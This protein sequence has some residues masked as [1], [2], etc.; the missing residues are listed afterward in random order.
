MRKFL[1]LGVGFAGFALFLTITAAALAGASANRSSAVSIPD[2][3][4]S[5]LSAVPGNDWVSP[6][7]NLAGNRYSSLTT[8]TPANVSGVKLAWHV[9]LN[10]PVPKG[11]DPAALFGD[12]STAVESGGTL[13]TSDSL[14]RVYAL[15]AATGKQLWYYEPNNPKTPEPPASKIP[16]P[17]GIS[18]AGAALGASRGVAINDGLV[19][20]FNEGGDA[21]ALD[22]STGKLVWSDQVAPLIQGVGLS[23]APLY[24]NGVIYGATA[25]GDQGEFPCFAFALDA[26]TGKMLW[27]FNIIPG[28]A[29]DP[30]YSTWAHPLPARGGGAMWDTPS[31]DPTTGDVYFGTGNPIPYMGLLR[32]PGQEHFTDG[33]LALNA[34][35]GKEAWFF[36][37]VHHDIWDADQSQAP[38]VYNGTVGGQ[39]VD[40]IVT[41]DK[42]GLWYVLDAATGKPVL[43]VTEMKVQQSA[44]AH[45]WAT[46]PIP[47]TT[48]LVPQTVPDPAAWKNLKAPNGKPWNIGPGGAAGS[49][50]GAD[51]TRYSVTAAFGQ[52]ASG[53]KPGSV[54]P[55]KGLLIEETTPGFTAYQAIPSSEVSKL[56]AFNFSAV[57]DM[58]IAPLTGTPAAAVTGTRIE[59]MS[60]ATGKMVWKVDHLASA[61][62]P[63]KGGAKPPPQN[64]FSGGLVTS[65]GLVW[66]SSS[67]Q[68][69]AYSEAN[70]KLL[71][72]SPTLPSGTFAPPTTYEVNGTQ[73]VI[74][75]LSA[76]HDLYAFS[77]S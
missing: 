76:T 56:T 22:A 11:K 34:A 48:P 41:A 66:A 65:P 51:A 20:A 10:E 45:T 3:S 43:P 2:L 9:K 36:Q 69:Q 75:E 7:G 31:V 23:M 68:L 60:I 58:K 30:G 52:G 67:N 59:A 25:A 50:V 15:D 16:N 70:G 29:S 28:Q 72:S 6:E 4:T 55:T 77:L 47:S 44:Q 46:Q 61:N 53:N 26:K 54:D 71:W 19:Y 35:T 62:K 14:G 39:K 38:M 57:A 42:D 8:I 74:L 21:V 5:T 27:K 18:L 1:R 32:G 33:V 13:F 37:E 40:A 63:G 17:F 49:F 24:Y 73:Y 12:E 64:T